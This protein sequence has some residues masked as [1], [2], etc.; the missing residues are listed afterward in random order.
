MYTNNNTNNRVQGT[1]CCFLAHGPQFQKRPLYYYQLSKGE[2]LSFAI[3]ITPLV[4]NRPVWMLSFSLLYLT[5][6]KVVFNFKYK[7]I[8][9]T[10]LQDDSN[11][12]V[13]WSFETKFV[14][15]LWYTGLLVYISLLSTCV[16]QSTVYW[17]T[18]VYCLLV[19]TSLLFTNVHQSTVYWC[20]LVY[21]LL[22]YAGLLSTGVHK[23][24]VYWCTLV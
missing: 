14:V 17:F 6:T 24:T 1:S 16:H 19:Y 22:V 9:R 10:R 8:R 4:H 7:E 5:K 23:S 13:K 18:L 2:S 21:C 11:L 3:Q 15:G 12:M 20:T